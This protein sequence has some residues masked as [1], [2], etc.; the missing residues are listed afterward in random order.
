MDKTLVLASKSPRRQELLAALGVPFVVETA[1]VDERPHPGESAQDAV[2]RLSRAKA[3]AV[4]QRLSRQPGGPAGLSSVTGRIAVLSADTIVTLD[5]LL[6]GKPVDSA[7]A[8]A[9]LRA[10]RGR[11][12]QVCTAVTL[13]QPNLTLTRLT[14]SDVFMRDYRDDEI[15]AYVATGDPMDKAGAYA[16]QHTEFAPVLR[17]N[18]CFTSIMGLPLG[19]VASMLLGAG[20]TPPT[21][22]SLGEVVEICERPHRTLRCCLRPSP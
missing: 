13:V 12:H 15:A 11:V 3:L 9:M 6:L 8:V 21:L 22:K 10:L 1:D 16:I 14:V 19:T 5:G 18:G 4:V 20:L 17:W 7:D 2:T